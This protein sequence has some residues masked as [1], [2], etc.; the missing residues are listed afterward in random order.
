MSIAPGTT[1]DSLVF[2]L[3][4]A[5]GPANMSV[6]YG[7]TVEHCGGGPVVWTLVGNGTRTLPDRIAYG[8]VIPGFASTAGPVPIG[9]GCYRIIIS[10]APP[11]SFDVRANGVVQARGAST[12]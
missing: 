9:T 1:R 8:Q 4:G 11:L 12:P 7:L 2:V 10:E 6:V 3:G 5:T